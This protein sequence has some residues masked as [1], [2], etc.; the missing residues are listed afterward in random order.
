[1][2][3]FLLL[4][5]ALFLVHSGIAQWTPDSTIN[6]TVADVASVEEIAPMMATTSEGFTYVS[7]F[8]LNQSTNMYELYMQ[9]LDTVGVELWAPGG[10]LISNQPQSQ[11]IFRYD[12]KVDNLDN[13]V[14]AFQDL[15]Q[16]TDYTIVVYKLDKAG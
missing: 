1:M 12:L 11:T 5:P 10:L 9:L 6:T 8:T 4:L 15:R 3:R 16:G 13:A 7:W 14:V 2:R